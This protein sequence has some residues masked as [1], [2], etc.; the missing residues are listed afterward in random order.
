MF[1]LQDNVPEVYVNSSRDFQLLCRIY[2]CWHGA[3]KFKIDSITNILDPETASDDVLELLA[4]RVGFFPRI[5]I[6]GNVLRNIISAFPYIIKNKG[7]Q[8][9]ITEA[10]NCILK[11]EVD[12]KSTAG[13][14]LTIKDN[15]V[16]I[17]TMN[18]IYNKA[19]LKEVLRYVLPFGYTYSLSLYSGV[20]NPTN[21][22]SV[23]SK[24]KLYKESSSLVGSVKSYKDYDDH[25]DTDLQG[26]NNVVGTYNTTPDVGK[27]DIIDNGN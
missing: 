13:V 16:D 11:A 12:P 3:S 23:I 4:T 25:T 18:D 21:I 5:H 15:N 7:T 9:G 22:A 10:V 6:D 1:R 17:K 14:I 19:A 24:V 26:Y 20:Y 2:D 8:L 27:E